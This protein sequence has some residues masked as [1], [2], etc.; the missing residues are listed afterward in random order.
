MYTF[1]NSN[2]ERLKATKNSM[3]IS[4]RMKLKRKLFKEKMVNKA[5]VLT[6]EI[7]KNEFDTCLDNSNVSNVF[8]SNTT[9][10]GVNTNIFKENTKTQK[11]IKMLRNRISAQKSR[12]K[13][14]KQN[15]FLKKNSQKLLYINCELNKNISQQK[16]EIELLKQNLGMI[17]NGCALK[18][19]DYNK[20]SKA[21]SG[22]LDLGTAGR[23]RF[24]QELFSST[25]VS[26]VSFSIDNNFSQYTK[27][28]VI[29]SL[30]V[31]V[32]IML[33]L[34]SGTGNLES[35][36]LSEIKYMEK[37]ILKMNNYDNEDDNE[38]NYN[39]NNSI[40]PNTQGEKYEIKFNLTE[41][42]DYD[43]RSSEGNIVQPF[44]KIFLNNI[45]FKQEAIRQFLR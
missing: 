13:V 12:D 5:K 22:E 18:I 45:D 32:C 16:N 42:N 34:L 3:T 23:N 24:N 1:Y 11:E 43:F 37:R 29:G 17:C 9:I 35:Y 28:G 39:L 7:T 26:N 30:L 21:Y 25:N 31:V 20:K 33:N 38:S 6:A 2:N 44:K 40:I 41:Q 36:A 15:E 8:E 4:E 14:K 27:L 10:E 19:N